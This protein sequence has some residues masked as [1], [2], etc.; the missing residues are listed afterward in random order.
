MAEDTRPPSAA[1]ITIGIYPGDNHPV[2]LEMASTLG[3]STDWKITSGLTVAALSGGGYRETFRFPLDGVRRSF[4]ARH[5]TPGWT[6][7]AYT[8]TVSAIPQPVTVDASTDGDS[9]GRGGGGGEED[10]ERFLPL[11]DAIMKEAGV[12]R[13]TGQEV[14][15]L[16]STDTITKTLTI[17][18]ADYTAQ[19]STAAWTRDVDG[20]YLYPTS[21]ERTFFNAPV[22]LPVGTIITDMEGQYYRSTHVDDLSIILLRSTDASAI[23][24]TVAFA[25]M[26]TTLSTETSWYTRSSAVSHTVL[27]DNQY[28]LLA[29]IAMNSASSQNVRLGHVT[30]T[31]TMSDYHESY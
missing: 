10:D 24:P 21:T 5:D 26:F 19:S 6:A 9:G 16:S 22:V 23:S 7:G 13:T 15:T 1:K 17:S 12:V 8:R 20:R 27:A 18:P 31:Y 11:A 29:N 4:R 2:R 3:S 14:G 28:F 30:L 25:D